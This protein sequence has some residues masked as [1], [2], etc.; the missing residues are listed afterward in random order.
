MVI[1]SSGWALA[2][3]I[4]RR[5]VEQAIVEYAPAIAEECEVLGLDPL[6]LLTALADV[7][8]RRG[9]H[10]DPA[11][12]KIATRWEP[13]YAE[14]GRWYS[15]ELS[16]RWGKAAESSWGPWQCMF[17]NAVRFGFPV[18]VDPADP[19]DGMASVRV[20]AE[21]STRM[22]ASE[23]RRVIG[24]RRAHPLDARSSLELIADT[25][26]SG[27][28]EGYRPAKYIHDVVAAYAALH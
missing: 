1:D 8:S 17:S 22:L 13:S 14:G 9:K 3:D 6:K 21:V 5:A 18:E 12:W 16:A 19:E 27:G 20:A 28:P 2:K 10:L 11:T 25:W 23:L 4:S 15:A 26:N 7:E 24:Y